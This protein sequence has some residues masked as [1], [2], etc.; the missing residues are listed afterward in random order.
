M[1]LYQEWRS[2]CGEGANLTMLQLL[3]RADSEYKRLHQLGQWITK[4]K[5][6]ELLGLQAKLD[7]LQN[8][9]VA[10]MSEHTKLKNNSK[11]PPNTSTR[12][13]GEPKLEENEERM[14]NGDK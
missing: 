7:L 3:A 4:N 8:Q 14:V 13:T 9:F 10:L 1:K 2:G 6:S 5:S 12:P 11:P